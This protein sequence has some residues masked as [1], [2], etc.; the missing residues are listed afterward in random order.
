MLNVTTVLERFI[1]LSGLTSNEAASALPFC[2]AAANEISEKMLSY[3][4][5]TDERLIMAAASMAFYKW[6][7]MSSS[8]ENDIL[9]SF[10]AGDVTVSCDTRATIAAA[11]SLKNDT[12]L[13]ASPL[14]KD[15]GF[16]FSQVNVYDN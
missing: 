2:S 10:K 14:L 9:S 15:N 12:L 8:G 3:A 5:D 11:E 6:T 4:S 16:C 1:L 7:L 13:S